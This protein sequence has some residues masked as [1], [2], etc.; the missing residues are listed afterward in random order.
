MEDTDFLDE[1][2]AITHAASGG[3]YNGQTATLTV[4]VADDEPA[5]EV[6]NA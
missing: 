6:L 1:T 5:P 3:G 2:V 4:T